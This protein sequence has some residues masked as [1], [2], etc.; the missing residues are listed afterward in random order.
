VDH[1][2]NGRVKLMINTPLGKKSVYD[3]QAMRLA[4]LRFGVPCITTVRAGLAA[5]SAVRSIRAGELRAIK[6]QQIHGT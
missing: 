5:I 3:E 6:L 4:G 2:R 1:V